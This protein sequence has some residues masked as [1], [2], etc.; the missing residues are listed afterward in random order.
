MH[1]DL[2]LN[3]NKV[4]TPLVI[5]SIHKLLT[6][7]SSMFVQQGVK[8]KSISHNSVKRAER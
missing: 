8:N 5:G 1:D 6:F 4:I 2:D 3:H 7:C